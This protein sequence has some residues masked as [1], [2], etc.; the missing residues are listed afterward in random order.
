MTTATEKTDLLVVGAGPAGLAAARTVAQAGYRV[1]AV[2]REDDAGGVPRHCFHTGFGLRDLHRPMTGPLYAK[3][4]VALARAAGVDIRTAT[5]ATDWASDTSM[6]TTSSRGR[7]CIDA[8]AV[9]LAT[10]CRERPRSARLVPGRRPAGVYTGGAMQQMVYLARHP[11]GRR[12]VIVGA[13]H[14]A[15]SAVHTLRSS[16]TEVAAVISPAA[17]L[18]T[19]RALRLATAGIAGVPVLYGTRIERIDGGPRVTSVTVT[20]PDGRRGHI[21]CDTVVFTGD[22]IPDYEMARTAGLDMDAATMGPIVDTAGATSRP[23]VF[24]AGNLVH[25]AEPADKAASN[26]TDIGRAIADHLAGNSARRGRINITVRRPLLWIAPQ[27][28]TAGLLPPRGRF[29]LRAAETDGMGTLVVE[30]NGR[31]VFE[32]RL[33]HRL[34]PNR[35]ITLPAAKW[36]PTLDSTGDVTISFRR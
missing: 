18:E 32:H 10:G 36:L 28:I 3:Q 11:I 12:A 21:G 25:P 30:Q 26:S 6:A 17:G 20:G 22:W 1:I 34:T 14:I 24:A 7:I 15:F 9:L 23:G 29:A 35:S 31:T 13:E 27:I 4:T 2:E 33:L 8:D 19:F 5:T 16:G